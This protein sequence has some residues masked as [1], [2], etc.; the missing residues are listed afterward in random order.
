MTYRIRREALIERTVKMVQINSINSSLESGPG[1]SEL[2]SYTAD[3]MR[4]AGLDVQHYEVEPGRPNVIGHWP[5]A[6][7]GRS[8]MLNAHLDTVG[9]SGMA[10]P[11][12]GRIEGGRLYGRGAQDMK[13]S[14]SAM[15]SAAEA[16]IASGQ[17]LA[18]DLW[19][20]AVCDEE[21]TSI[22]AEDL[23]RHVKADAA[24]ITEPTDLKLCR[25]H[26]GMTWFEVETIG[27]AAHGS[28][29]LEGIDA[30]MRMGRFLAALE[31]HEI[32]LRHRP[33]HPL[34]GPPS[35]HAAMLQGGTEP[36]MYAARCK[37]TLERRTVPGEDASL[38]APAIQ[39]IIDHLAAEDESFR[40]ELSLSFE[41]PPFEISAQ[42]EIVQTLDSASE[43]ILG[44]AAEHVGQTFWT[45]AAIFAEA[46]MQSALIGP[47][48][49]GLHSSEEWVDLQSVIQLAQILAHSARLYCS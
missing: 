7:G 28:R 5:G 45:D 23:V 38:A 27:Q 21:Y 36:S 15:I 40:A 18:G 46:V 22:G 37:A 9:V 47:I 39:A 29:F 16:L 33:P 17:R 12:S 10:E 26:R 41:R 3:Q 8:L 25:A 35:L 19:I 49:A 6:G 30:N 42:A 24:I 44:S 14:L 48:G 11:F 31:A 20:T 4:A 2:A 1:E 32:E 43:Q 13:A 34:T